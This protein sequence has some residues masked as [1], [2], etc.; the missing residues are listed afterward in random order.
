MNAR[1][2][3]FSTT[4]TTARAAATWCARWGS[5]PIGI[6]SL[7]RPIGC[8]SRHGGTVVFAAV[9]EHDRQHPWAVNIVRIRI[10]PSLPESIRQLVSI[11]SFSGLP[12]AIE[13]DTDVDV[14]R[15]LLRRSSPSASIVRALS[16][17]NAW[18]TSKK[19][20]SG[21]YAHVGP[22]THPS[23]SLTVDRHISRHADR[24]RLGKIAAMWNEDVDFAS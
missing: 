8:V 3:S 7:N 15:L 20:P 11:R 5:E 17:S 14:V 6:E 4:S 19:N 22:A 21:W 12:T 18:F 1:M 24:Q 2:P 10:E 13:S 23:R 9:L 16:R